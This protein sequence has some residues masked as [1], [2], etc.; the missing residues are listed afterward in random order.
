MADLPDLVVSAT[1]TLP[2]RL[3]D[4][5]MS[6]AGG[7]GGQHVNKTETKVDLRLD[8]DGAVEV[9]GE[10]AV[11]RVREVWSTR[12]DAEGRLCVVCSL[13]RSRQRNLEAAHAQLEQMVRDALKPRRVRRKT[14]P[15]RG[16]KERRIGE[17]KRRGGIKRLRRDP[18][19]E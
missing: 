9:L 14:K 13:H 19:A 4:V 2:G 15:T 3:L 17:K 11:A 5:R 8:L 6:R 10:A 7:P 1:R 16:S 12:L 18:G